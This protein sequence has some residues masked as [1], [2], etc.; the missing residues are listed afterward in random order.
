MESLLPIDEG[1]ANHIRIPV[2]RGVLGKGSGVGK[3]RHFRA[4]GALLDNF[5]GG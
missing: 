4:I 1:C 5:G 3:S 2:C